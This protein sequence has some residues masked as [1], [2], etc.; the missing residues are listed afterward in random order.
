MKGISDQEFLQ[1]N[2]L[3]I[4]NIEE[5]FRKYKYAILSG[6]E[7]NYREFIE[8]ALS[9]NGEENSFFDC[10]YS[11]LEETGREKF[12]SNLTPLEKEELADME[13]TQAVYY[14]LTEKWI[15]LVSKVTAG[16]T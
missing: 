3:H 15:P 1:K 6:T 14:P 9:M 5:G 10:Y 4:S 8:C 16:E 11:R 7:E 12:R 2:L 13:Q